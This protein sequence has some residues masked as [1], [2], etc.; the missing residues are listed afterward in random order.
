MM[1]AKIDDNNEHS[2]IA[3]SSVDLET[4]IRL[5]ADPVTRRLLVQTFTF[6][7]SG[8]PTSTPTTVGQMY[9]DTAAA[10]VYI[11]TGT[12]SSADWSILN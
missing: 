1:N 10:K 3:V 9:I 6:S 2:L 11:S 5:V 12:A 8:A 4:P 7:G